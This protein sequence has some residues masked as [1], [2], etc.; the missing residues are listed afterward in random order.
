MPSEAS[1]ELLNIGR[2]LVPN[3]RP[4]QKMVSQSQPTG[5]KRGV[6]VGLLFVSEAGTW[7]R[8]ARLI[9]DHP[10]VKQ[11]RLDAD[12]HKVTVG[13]YKQTL[14]QNTAAYPKRRAPGARG[15]MERG[16]G[17]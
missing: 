9:E 7:S 15:R 5:R 13:F 11:V 1:R 8:V 14:L 17:S 12:G 2:L 3:G 6:G 4:W 16:A 10:A